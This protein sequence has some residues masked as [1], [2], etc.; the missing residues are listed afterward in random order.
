MTAHGRA[1]APNRL[2]VRLAPLLLTM[3]LGFLA[4]SLPLPALPLHVRD[5]LGFNA[6]VAGLVV[7]V[8]SLATVLTRI[9][10]GRLV[11]GRGPKASVVAGLLASSAAGWG[12][13][14][15]CLPLLGPGPSLAVLVAGRL[16]LGAG[17]S[18]LIT[19]VLS[20]AIVRAGPGRAGAAMSWNGIAQYGALALGAPCGFALSRV[21][22]FAAPAAAGALVPL[23]ALA[24]VGPLRAV[25]VRAAARA[26]VPAML[27]HV[28]RPGAGLLLGGVGFAAVS[29]FASLD[30][31]ARHWPGTGFAL[32]AYG[33]GFVAVRLLAG[34]LPDR[35]GG[36]LVAAGSLAVEGV[37]QLLLWLAPGPAVALAGAGLT[38]MGCSLLF[39]ALG[40]EAFRRVPPEARGL[41]VATFAAFQDVAIGTTGPL[42]GAVATLTHPSAVFAAGALA[43]AGGLLVA[44][45]LRPT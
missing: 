28:W 32:F 19:G 34:G 7:G 6:A 11:D 22:G 21:A 9:P 45:R 14:A 43:A 18:L 17:E 33:G 41:A 16:L 4:V 5:G 1:A 31:A 36:V 44:L 23:L 40:I 26:P 8:Q 24:A 10:A 15:S 37:G 39:P 25:T 35:V 3:A 13:L 12:C 42:L 29:A 38:G 30:F 20:W 27:G 2:L